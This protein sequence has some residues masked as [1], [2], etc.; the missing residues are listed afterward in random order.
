MIISPLSIIIPVYN[1]VENIPILTK[2]IIDALG[3]NI[4]FEILFINDGSTDDTDVIL[5]KLKDELKVQ[6]INHKYNSGQSSALLTGIKK[7]KYET[8]VTLDGDC[9]NDPADIKSLLEI[10]FS[11][12]NI[13]LVG[14]IRTKRRDNL[15][16]I[17]SS[18]LANLVRSKILNDNC[19]DTG[20]GLKIIDKDVFLNL[21]FFNGIHRFL[22]ALYKGMGHK[23][24]F[25]PVNHRYRNKGVSKYGTL[26]RLIYGIIDILHVRQILK[27]NKNV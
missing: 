1:E 8:I 19:L 23:T 12:E 7:S 2:E 14:G 18:R 24:K 16:K 27:S 25:L 17:F 5:K 22:P 13:K 20:C 21:P 26:K 15:I 9:Q 3:T 11:D 6:Y 4:N 10:Y